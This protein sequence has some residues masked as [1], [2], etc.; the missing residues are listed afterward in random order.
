MKTDLTPLTLLPLVAAA[1]LATSFARGQNPPTGAIIRV[2][3]PTA[4]LNDISKFDQSLALVRQT[5][6]EKAA[7]ELKERLLPAR[8]ENDILTKSGSCGLSKHLRDKKLI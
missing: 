6:G 5:S 7:A 8:Q 4:C 3:Q 2:Q 1:L